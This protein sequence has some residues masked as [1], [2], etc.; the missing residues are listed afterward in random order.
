MPGGDFTSRGGR[1][2]NEPNGSPSAKRR[3]PSHERTIR[4]ADRAGHGRRARDRGSDGDALRR[5]GREGGDL[6]PRSPTGGGGRRADP[7]QRRSGAGGRPRRGRER[8][9]EGK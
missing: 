5:R 3:L 2:I 4:G 9:G 7:K 1:R 8:G 6:R